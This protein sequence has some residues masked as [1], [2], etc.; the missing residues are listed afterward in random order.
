MGVE[1]YFRQLVAVF[2]VKQKQGSETVHCTQ[3]VHPEVLL[4]TQLY[5]PLFTPLVNTPFHPF[6]TQVLGVLLAIDHTQADTILPYFMKR[7]TNVL[8]KQGM[9]N[10]ALLE[11]AFFALGRS[12]KLANVPSEK[13]IAMQ[14]SRSECLEQ[15][16]RIARWDW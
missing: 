1:T 11:I 10:T 2:M 7:L 4:N 3:A 15:S 16:W 14:E 8:W 9:M 13:L 5:G 6:Q 12:Q